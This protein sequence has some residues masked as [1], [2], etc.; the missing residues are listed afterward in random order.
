MGGQVVFSAQLDP[1]WR[2]N[3]IKATVVLTRMGLWEA[4]DWTN[5]TIS[6]NNGTVSSAGLNVYNCDDR[7]GISPNVRQNYFSTVTVIDGDLPAAT[8][9]TITPGQDVNGFYLGQSVQAPV[10]LDSAAWTGGTEYSSSGSSGGSDQY[11]TP[12]ASFA[13]VSTINLGGNAFAAHINP[14]WWRP[15]IRTSAAAGS[16]V[17]AYLQ[18]VIQSTPS[19][20]TAPSAL[21]ATRYLHPLSLLRVPPYPSVSFMSWTGTYNLMVK[22][23]ASPIG[24]F[25]FDCLYLMG[26]DSYLEVGRDDTLYIGNGHIMVEASDMINDSYV[27]IGVGGSYRLWNVRAG[28]GIY[29]TPGRTNYISLLARNSNA[30][31]ITDYFS[32]KLAYKPRKLAL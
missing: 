7:S 11:I 9:L 10:M 2:R 22:S 19:G 1:R 32:V 28:T 25:R 6:N 4:Y 21:S 5:V 17:W 29:L 15:F 24:L 3:Q 18:T 16:G 12:T 31:A 8:Q 13:A 26:T 27:S 23:L 20:E 14:G 30:S